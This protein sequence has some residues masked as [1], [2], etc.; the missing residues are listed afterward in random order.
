MQERIQKYMARCGVASRRK[1][2]EIIT[3]GRVKVNG[4][5]VNDIVIIDD[6]KDVVQVD[7]K[8]IK[9]EL[10]KIYIMLNKPV[11]V[12]TT[13]SD[14]FG[15]KTVT[16]MVNIS[17]R[18]YPVGRLDFD[19]SGLLL[20]TND[21]DMAYKLTHPSHEISKLYVAKIIG[22]P[23]KDEIERFKNGLVIENYTTSKADIR[24][25]ESERNNS[26]VEVQIHEGKNRQV[27]KMCEK[28]GHPVLN[29][30][31]IAVGDLKIGGLET[32]KWR[33]LSKEE[34][35]YLKLL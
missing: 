23:S 13:A 21:G 15:R 10:D 5:V 22:I 20:L 34:I 25:I 32:G 26:T 18:I 30:K 33:Y 8:T 29:L 19:T 3:Q 1:S 35:N 27:R 14:E 28:I 4:K 12:V 11:G 16:E 17:E 24:I 6:E 31:R 2:E 9:P 7:G